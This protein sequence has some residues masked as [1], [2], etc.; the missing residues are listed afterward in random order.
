M[1]FMEVVMAKSNAKKTKKAQSNPLQVLVR[2]LEKSL[3]LQAAHAS[4]NSNGSCST[5]CSCS[6]LINPE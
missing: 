6:G 4:G 3:D 2:D 1:L 5:Y